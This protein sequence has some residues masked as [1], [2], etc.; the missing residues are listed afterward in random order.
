V[1]VHGVCTSLSVMACALLGV[2]R[3][4]RETLVEVRLHVIHRKFL[5]DVYLG[6]CSLA[7]NVSTSFSLSQ[8]ESQ[9]RLYGVRQQHIKN[10]IT[11]AVCA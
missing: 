11:R 6:R 1:R 5:T 4:E 10:F 9:A 8:P 7:F 2:K 3:V